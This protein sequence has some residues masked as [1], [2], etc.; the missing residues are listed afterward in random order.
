VIEPHAGR[1]EPIASICALAWADE[2]DEAD[3]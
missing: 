3:E 1:V 2:A